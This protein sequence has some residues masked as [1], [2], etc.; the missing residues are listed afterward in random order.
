MEHFLF[1]SGHDLFE[2]CEPIEVKKEKLK[3]NY[4]YDIENLIKS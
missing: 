2:W 3:V 1:G 4:R